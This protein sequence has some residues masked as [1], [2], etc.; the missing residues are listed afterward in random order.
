MS[1][2]VIDEIKTTNNILHTSFAR[3]SAIKMAKLN[4]KLCA[5]LQNKCKF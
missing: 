5:E 3:S 1:L 2:N 4:F